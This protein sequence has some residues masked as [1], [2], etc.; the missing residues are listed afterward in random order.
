MNIGID[1]DGVMF[2]TE[3]FLRCYADFFDME[4][5]GSGVVDNKAC[6]IQKRFDWL[7]SQIKDF[8]YKY[9]KEIQKN[10]PIM[11]GVVEVLNA[12]K[13][14][15]HRLIV[16]SARGSIL[17]EELPIAYECLKKLNVEFDEVCLNA[18]NKLPV[19]KEQKI[20][21]MIDDADTNI[22][23]LS[24]GG[25]KCLYF[26]SVVGKDVINDNVVDVTNWAE[27]LRYFK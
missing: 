11:P 16:I 26:R 27:V 2:D 24:E 25:I 8:I 10:S 12:L 6:R 17:D 14:M 15:G 9:A 3:S 20:D 13:E 5:G 4:I 19:C 23:S 7:D 18:I 1:I 22:I 21:V